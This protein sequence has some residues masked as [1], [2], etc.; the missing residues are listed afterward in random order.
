[1]TRALD[2]ATEIKTYPDLMVR[3]DVAHLLRRAGEVLDELHLR[4]F[5]HVVTEGNRV[6]EAGRAMSADDFETFGRLMS[7]SHE[8]LRLDFGVSTPELD[9]LVGIALDEGAAGARLTGAGL[10]GCVVALTSKETTEQVLRA[11][12]DKYY[13]KTQFKGELGDHLFVAEPSGGARVTPH[14]I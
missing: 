5:R 8:S 2:V 7:A 11:L 6:S 13:A 14:E 10:G 12:A 1:M 9:E 4:R 3:W